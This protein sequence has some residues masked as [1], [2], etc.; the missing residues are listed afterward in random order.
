MLIHVIQTHFFGLS[1]S[2]EVP[3]VCVLSNAIDGHD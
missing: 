1:G 2:T 3:I